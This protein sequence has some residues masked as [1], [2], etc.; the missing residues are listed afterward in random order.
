MRARVM[1]GYCLWLSRSIPRIFRISITNNGCQFN[2][3]CRLGSVAV[4]VNDKRD[5][6]F[7]VIMD[8][9]VI[10]SIL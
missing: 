9:D 7:V 6:Y 1:I 4:R 8:V 5:I 2:S 3:V 10:Y